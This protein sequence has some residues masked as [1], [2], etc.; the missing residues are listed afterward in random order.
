MREDEREH[1]S[2]ARATARVHPYNTRAGEKGR[3]Q[4]YAPTIHGGSG[5]P[6]SCIVGVYPCGRPSEKPHNLRKNLTTYGKIS[7]RKKRR[8]L[9]DK[10]L[11]PICHL[12]RYYIERG[13]AAG[14]L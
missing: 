11:F 8:P 2:V 1:R 13:L 9:K 3:P 7:Q 12:T 5:F 6:S 4:G 14:I 10:T